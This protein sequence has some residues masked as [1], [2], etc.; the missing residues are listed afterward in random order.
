MDGRWTDDGRL[1]DTILVQNKVINTKQKRMFAPYIQTCNRIT[2]PK[3]YKECKLEGSLV[4]ERSLP[5]V[6][7][8]KTDFAA[9]PHL[10]I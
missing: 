10:L 2:T 3:L 4:M 9:L 7:A 6:K 5:K 1:N 8:L